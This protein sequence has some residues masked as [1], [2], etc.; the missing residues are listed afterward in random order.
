MGRP[1]VQHSFLDVHMRGPGNPD[2]AT[3]DIL[4]LVYMK[5]PHV[6]LPDPT[7]KRARNIT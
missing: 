6:M 7:S 2:A 5:M 3:T 1:P 4:Y